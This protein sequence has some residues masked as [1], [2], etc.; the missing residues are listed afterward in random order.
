MRTRFQEERKY[1]KKVVQRQ[2]Q[3]MQREPVDI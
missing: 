1:R 3:D 2:K